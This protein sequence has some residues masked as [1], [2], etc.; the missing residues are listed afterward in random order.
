MGDYP[1]NNEENR[2]DMDAFVAWHKEITGKD[3]G[4]TIKKGCIQFETEL[5]DSSAESEYSC[6][7]DE[8]SDGFDNG[9]EESEC[10]D[11]QKAHVEERHEGYF[12]QV[13]KD[14]TGIVVDTQFDWALGVQ[15]NPQ[16]RQSGKPQGRLAVHRHL[17]AQ[18]RHRDG[19]RP[20]LHLLHR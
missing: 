3:V 13:L 10:N 11:C 4:Y 1:E 7:C 14:V 12:A 9:D 8:G 18:H 15:E 2:R 17:G 5:I 20:R 19:A 6:H 16:D